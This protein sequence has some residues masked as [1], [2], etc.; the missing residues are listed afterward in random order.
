MIKIKTKVKITKAQADLFNDSQEDNGLTKLNPTSKDDCYWMLKVEDNTLG[1]VFKAKIYW[2]QL[3]EYDTGV[4]E[5][6]LG[7]NEVLVYKEDFELDSTQVQNL[8]ESIEGEILSTD[9]YLEKIQE[10]TTQGILIWCGSVRDIFEIGIEN[11]E[12]V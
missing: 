5:D 1:E 12:V 2:Y 7:I 10:F 11:F 8:W 9:N 4:E 3:Q 6:P